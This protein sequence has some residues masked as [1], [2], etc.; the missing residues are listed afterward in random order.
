MKQLLNFIS[1]YWGYLKGAHYGRHYNQWF[2]FFDPLFGEH[3][4]ILKVFFLENFASRAVCTQE[5]VIVGV[6]SI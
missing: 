1:F 4:F 6:Y 3:D 2:I 5:Q